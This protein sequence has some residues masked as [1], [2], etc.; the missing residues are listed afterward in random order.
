MYTHTEAPGAT[1]TTTTTPKT[2]ALL[3]L[4]SWYI[5]IAYARLVFQY[6]NNIYMYIM[7]CVI[8][9]VR[10]IILNRPYIYTTIY[11]RIVLYWYTSPGRDIRCASYEYIAGFRLAKKFNRLNQSKIKSR[12]V[13]ISIRTSQCNLTSVFGLTRT[14]NVRRRKNKI[15]LYFHTPFH[16]YYIIQLQ[17]STIFY[18]IIGV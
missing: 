3:L 8:V 2:A 9:G 7:F 17:Y 12:A 16:T 18:N 11:V 13:L 4:S 15:L 10:V 5:I 6:N 1:T 14:S